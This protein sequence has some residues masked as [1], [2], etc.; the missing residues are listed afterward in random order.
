MY[1]TRWEKFLATSAGFLLNFLFMVAQQPQESHI[2]RA[3]ISAIYSARTNLLLCRYLYVLAA[4]APGSGHRDK[5]SET[6]ETR[7]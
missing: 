6:G 1:L 3:H 4:P 2:P 7:V 5:T